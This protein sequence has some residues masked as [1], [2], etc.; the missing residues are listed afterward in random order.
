MFVTL[1]ISIFGT[2]NQARR[3]ANTE[4][5]SVFSNVNFL[6]FLYVNKWM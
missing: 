3:R 6:F 5:N 1:S 4:K 2:V